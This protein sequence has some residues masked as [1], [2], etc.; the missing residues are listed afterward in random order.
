MSKR[1]S[2]R[3]FQQNLTV[4]LGAAKHGDSARTLLGVESGHGD[5]VH[6][7]I[8]LADSGEVIPLS[9]LTPVPLTRH[10]FSGVTNVRGMLYSV[11]DFSAFRAGTVTPH[12]S[13]ARLVMIGARHGINSAILVDRTLGLRPLDSMTR[14]PDDPQAPPWGHQRF[15]DADGRQWRRLQVKDLLADDGFLDVAA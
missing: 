2:L 14:L 3:E 4:R 12:N 5:N 10:W 9:E 13:E 7:L 11:I 6:W 15:E 1:I 8:D